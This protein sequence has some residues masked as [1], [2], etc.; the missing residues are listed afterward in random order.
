MAKGIPETVLDE[1]G[2]GEVLGPASL[3][4]EVVGE[5]SGGVGGV[6]S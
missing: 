5:K 2:S 4:G 6:R 3:G 1:Q